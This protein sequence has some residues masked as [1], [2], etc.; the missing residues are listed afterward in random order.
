MGYVVCLDVG[1]FDV[2]LY[3]P[4]DTVC[5]ADQF[6]DMAQPHCVY[7]LQIKNEEEMRTPD[8]EFIPDNICERFEI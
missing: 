8:C 1:E 3:D 6:R 4:F 7:D 5:A 2:P